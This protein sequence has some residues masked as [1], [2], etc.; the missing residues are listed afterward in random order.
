MS[1]SQTAN[2]ITGN[3]AQILF[4]GQKAMSDM[5][6]KQVQVSAQMQVTAQQQQVAL[7]AV[8]MMTGVGSKID[9][10]V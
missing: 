10:Y 8:A 4:D 5:A 2:N 9:T 7:E 6:M 1:I 3:L